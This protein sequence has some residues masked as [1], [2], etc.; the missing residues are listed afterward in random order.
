[1]FLFARKKKDVSIG[2]YGL[3]NAG[4]TT[5]LYRMKSGEVLKTIPTIGFN[6]ESVNVLNEYNHVTAWD[7]GGRSGM[8]SLSRHYLRTM[9]GIIFVVDSNDVD[10]MEQAAYELAY[11]SNTILELKLP[12]VILANKQDLKNALSPYDVLQKM[13]LDKCLDTKIKYTI[14]GCS[15]TSSLG[16]LKLQISNALNFICSLRK[17]EEEKMKDASGTK[18]I[19]TAVRAYFKNAMAAI[20]Q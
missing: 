4:K 14:I 13:K 6:V 18:C 15:T 9:D 17:A 19:V 10:R 3:D 1:M 16:D 20:F 8:R 12:V 2:L 11:F 5:L 7:V